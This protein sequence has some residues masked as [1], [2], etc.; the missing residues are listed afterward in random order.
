MYKAREGEF[1]IQ[2]LGID[3]ELTW[4]AVAWKYDFK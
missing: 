4:C 2:D 1:F 3:N